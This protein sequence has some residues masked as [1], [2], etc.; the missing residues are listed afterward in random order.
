[1]EDRE[2]PEACCIREAEE[3][4]GL[5][6]RPLRRFLELHEYYEECRYIS[7]YF[8]CEAL[9]SGQRHLTEPEER[10]GLE[11]RWLSL[12]E[13]VRLFSR[14]ASYDGI[15]EERR[16]TYLREYT[17]LQEYMNDTACDPEQSD[18]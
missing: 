11:P 12:Q 13:A 2:T 5:I 1:M 8:V 10:R 6:I 3:E 18:A 7:Y 4:T 16:G 14:H 17:A 15:D 9:G